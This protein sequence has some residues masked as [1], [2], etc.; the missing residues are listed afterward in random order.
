MV[1]SYCAITQQLSTSIASFGIKRQCLQTNRIVVIVLARKFLWI[2]RQTSKEEQWK[3]KLLKQKSMTIW[4]KNL[5]ELCRQKIYTLIKSEREKKFWKN[6]KLRPWTGW[7]L[8]QIT[9]SG[10]KDGK[11]LIGRVDMRAGRFAQR[12]QREFP[13]FFQ[14]WKLSLLSF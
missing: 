7:T 8:F 3:N 11:F 14:L 6:F 4:A 10:F 2:N 5:V 13:S 12:S 9:I 1:V